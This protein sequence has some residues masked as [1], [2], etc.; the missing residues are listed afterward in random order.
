MS[1]ADLRVARNEVF[2]RH[3]RAFSSEDLQAHFG[4]QAW[5]QVN[6]DYSDA[7]L[8]DDEKAN[9]AL[10]A[11]F[12]TDRDPVERYQF[13]GEPTLSFAD[14][15]TVIVGDFAAVYEGSAPTFNYSKHGDWVFVWQGSFPMSADAGNVAWYELNYDN[16]SVK[17]TVAHAERTH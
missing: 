11:S 9:V 15:H 13:S 12:E 4:G 14:A 1:K 10:I 7:M 3:G 5:Y 6:P 8:S 2:A 16:A 17:R